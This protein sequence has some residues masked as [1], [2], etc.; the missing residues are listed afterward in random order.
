MWLWCSSRQVPIGRY[1]ARHSAI[2][3]RAVSTPI[4]KSRCRK[5]NPRSTHESDE[6]SQITQN[7]I[8]HLVWTHVAALKHVPSRAHLRNSRLH[9]THAS[10]A[11]LQY[12]SM[13]ISLYVRREGLFIANKLLD[14]SAPCRTFTHQTN[15]ICPLSWSTPF[16]A[17]R[18]LICTISTI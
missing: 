16:G 9:S 15:Q 18:S 4:I 10:D 14:R 6:Y 11:I 12:P 1:T 13:P 5:G 17:H 3:Q 7:S 2:R 8:H